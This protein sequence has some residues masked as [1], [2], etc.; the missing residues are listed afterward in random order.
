M[1]GAD[2]AAGG[3]GQI[4]CVTVKRLLRHAN[5]SVLEP[6]YLGEKAGR[7]LQSADIL[8]VRERGLISHVSEDIV[9]SGR[10]DDTR[11]QLRG[12]VGAQRQVDAAGSCH[13]D[14]DF[15]PDGADAGDFGRWIQRRADGR[16][17]MM[18]HIRAPC[19]DRELIR[20]TRGVPAGGDVVRHLSVDA[21]VLFD[22]C[23]ACEARRIRR[24]RLLQARAPAYH[25]DRVGIAGDLVGPRTRVDELVRPHRIRGAFSLD[26]ERLDRLNSVAATQGSRSVIDHLLFGGGRLAAGVKCRGQEQWS[27]PRHPLH[28]DVL[29]A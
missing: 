21:L 28:R 20:D 17:W 12:A 22:R 24:P 1:A 18:V 6:V 10:R 11:R 4:P 9:G 15:V 19:H 7:Q 23:L 27:E 14:D 2:R 13:I 16:H 25:V 3:R 8:I 26:H 5:V 29:S